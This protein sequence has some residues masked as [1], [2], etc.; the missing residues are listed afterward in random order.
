MVDGH[1]LKTV[2]SQYLSNG[3]AAR[4]KLW[5]ALGPMNF[6]HPPHTLDMECPWPNE[7][8][9]STPYTRYGMPL[10]Q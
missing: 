5:N 10:A 1:H 3:L 6:T 4:R 9:L 8:Y 2:K 7:L